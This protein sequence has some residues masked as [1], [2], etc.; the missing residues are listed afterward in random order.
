MKDQGK[1]ESSRAAWRS[2]LRFAAIF[3]G[4]GVFLLF[5][6]VSRS[7]FVTAFLGLLFGV[8]IVP[9]VAWL[10]RFRIPRGLGAAL[11]VFAFFAVLSGVVLLL[12]PI[13]QEQG[14]ELQQ[15]LPEAIDRIDRELLS[16]HI[17][18]NALEG[19]RAPSAAVR[20]AT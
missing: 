10:H 16:R 15:R 4:V 2:P 17:L 6:W 18:T 19:G 12:A 14:K 13:L 11:I 9:P 8:S 1:E 5:L 20:A 7:I 3:F